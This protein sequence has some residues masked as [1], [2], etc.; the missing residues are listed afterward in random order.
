MFRI[1]RR[2]QDKSSVL[3][4]VLQQISTV[5]ERRQRKAADYLNSKTAN[6]SDRD[7]F[8]W[9]SLLTMVLGGGAVVVLW[10]SFHQLTYSVQIKTIRMPAHTLIAPDGKRAYDSLAFIEKVFQQ[11]LK[12]SDNG[13][14]K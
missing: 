2:K 13:K 11:Q 4:G 10:Q 8:I 7:I 12:T 5:V 1:F 14:E 6:W 3:H 9:F